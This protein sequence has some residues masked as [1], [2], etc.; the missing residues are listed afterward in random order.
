MTNKE[1]RNKFGEL[2]KEWKENTFIHSSFY[3]MF[4]DP[5]YQAI[6]ELGRPV[7]PLLFE[8]LQKEPDWW[9]YAIEKITGENPPADK[10]MFSFDLLYLTEQYLKWGKTKGLVRPISND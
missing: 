5:S 3:M 9:F 8:E 6:I 2:K 4:N 1:L 10:Q 7:L